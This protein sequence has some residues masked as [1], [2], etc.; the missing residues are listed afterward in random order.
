[1]GEAGDIIRK[2]RRNPSHPSTC[3]WKKA[4]IEAEK[5]IKIKVINKIIQQ[6]NNLFWR[7]FW[8]FPKIPLKKMT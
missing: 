7:K 5:V 2:S 4:R 6:Y 1:M 8:C 3:S